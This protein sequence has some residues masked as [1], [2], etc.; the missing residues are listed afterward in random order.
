MVEDA[1]AVLAKGWA[2]A[3]PAHILK[4][5]LLETKIVRSLGCGQ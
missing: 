2:G 3:L 1:T 5:V 4:G